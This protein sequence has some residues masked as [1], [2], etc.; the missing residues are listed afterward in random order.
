M[1]GLTAAKG[2]TTRSGDVRRDEHCVQPRWWH[3][4][5]RLIRDR[6][7]AVSKANPATILGATAD[8]SL[9]T[10]IGSGYRHHVAES[11]EARGVGQLQ[12]LRRTHL[13]SLSLMI[14][15]LDGLNFSHAVIDHI[16]SRFR[17]TTI[18]PYCSAQW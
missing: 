14:L 15:D 6:S 12:C 3:L 1:C 2:I 7:L 5:N 18:F 17:Y 13:R 4:G 16:I 9:Q 11:L 8:G 10:S